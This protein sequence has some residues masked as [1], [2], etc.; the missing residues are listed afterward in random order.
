MSWTRMR[1]VEPGVRGACVV[2]TEALGGEVEACSMLRR[3]TC[4]W[5][6]FRRVMRQRTVLFTAGRAGAV[7]RVLGAEARTTEMV[8][9]ELGAIWLVGFVV[10]F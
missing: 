2:G 10:P 4:A 5:R 1:P 9:N 6:G 3:E 8:G 7:S